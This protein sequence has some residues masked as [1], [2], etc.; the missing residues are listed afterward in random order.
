[1]K[2]DPIKKVADFLRERDE[3][4]GPYA[5]DDGERTES[6][7][8]IVALL[9][10]GPETLALVIEALEPFAASI[11]RMARFQDDAV[12]DLNIYSHAQA[13]EDSLSV[14][15]FRRASE[16]LTALREMG[17]SR[18]L[19]Q[20]TSAVT[21]EGEASKQAELNATFAEHV[22]HM[23]EEVIP[24]I[25]R[26]LREQHRV[27]HFLR[28]GLAPVHIDIIDSV[29][30]EVDGHDQLSI[31]GG[32]KAAF[33]EAVAAL[34]A[35]PPAPASCLGGESGEAGEI[36]KLIDP[37]A[38]EPE[39]P[40][41]QFTYQTLPLAEAQALAKAKARRILAALSPPGGGGWKPIE[42]VPPPGTRF[43]ALFDDGS[44][45]R[46]FYAADEDQFYDH[47]GDVIDADYLRATYHVWAP[48]PAG[49]R[50]WCE[51]REDDPMRFP[52]PPADGLLSGQDGA[53]TAHVPNPDVPVSPTGEG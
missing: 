40:D 52:A 38:F 26:D 2:P 21:G 3:A 14:S 17:S 13:G 41:H 50:L 10:P 49:F 34:S 6:A 45:A 36:A 1:M 39:T 20:T 48:L 7:K 47:D 23:R 29:L 15:N 11:A 16:A 22:Q 42:T 19:A 30:E 25:D 35:A 43:A 12:V 37:S 9:T 8:V 32:R 31:R 44:G 27:A 5:E 46:L 4:L 53:S 24:A 33:C 18:D 28:L 51:T